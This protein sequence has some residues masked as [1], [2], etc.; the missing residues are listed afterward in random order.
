MFSH[1]FFLP[2]IPPSFPSPLFSSPQSGPSNPTK[3]FGGALLAGKTAFAASRHVTRALTTPFA[4]G[5][6]RIY[7]MYSEPS[8]CVWS[9]QM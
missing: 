7:M 6:K 3:E 2:L 8:E 5:R 9:L 4:L 1:V